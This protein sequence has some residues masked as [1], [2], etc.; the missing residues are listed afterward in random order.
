M[1]IYFKNRIDIHTTNSV[2]GYA[3]IEFHIPGSDGVYYDLNDTCLYVKCKISQ[4]DPAKALVVGEVGPV[5]LLLS[6]LFSDIELKLND[7]HID[8]GDHAYSY[9][10]YLNTILNFTRNVKD[11]QLRAAGYMYDEPGKFDSKDNVAY[12]KRSKWIKNEIEVAGALHLLLFQQSKYLLPGVNVFLKFIRNKEE[13][14]IMDF[15]ANPAKLEILSM[16]LYTRRVTVI[17]AGLKGHEDGLLKSNTLY[18]V[19]KH[20]VNTY[21]LAIGSTTDSREILI[22]SQTPK[23]VVV[24]FVE[25]DA[26]NGNLL[27]SPFNFQHFNLTSITLMKNGVPIPY[28]TLHMDFAKDNYLTA[29]IMA[30]QNLGMGLNDHTNDITMKDF[31][32]GSTLFV[33]NLAADLEIGGGCTQPV[34]FCNLRL[35]LNFGKALKQSIN[36]IV[37]SVYDQTIE[38]TKSRTILVK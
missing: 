7:T 2:Q 24:G 8:G 14:V 6:S 29:Y 1:F 19:H 26:Y 16:I 35:D 28:P 15:G 12:T 33:Y 32:N 36:V 38:I 31:S 25:N 34:Q 11:T 3:P 5:N 4:A 17:P 21:T 37:F 22:G 30:L 20:R 18:P 23:L 10:A 13:F 9:I 27:K